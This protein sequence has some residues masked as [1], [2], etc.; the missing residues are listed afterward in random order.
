MEA[1]N[2]LAEEARAYREAGNK[3]AREMEG[4]YGAGVGPAG[5]KRASRCEKAVNANMES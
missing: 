3:E 1:I 2:D 4:A 5:M